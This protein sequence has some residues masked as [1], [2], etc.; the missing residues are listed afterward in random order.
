MI[1]L[2][3]INPRIRIGR[4]LLGMFLVFLLCGFSSCTS[5][6]IAH[7]KVVDTSPKMPVLK[8]K[9][10]VDGIALTVSTKV[11]WHLDRIDQLSP[12]LNG[13]FE[14]AG[15]GLGVVIYVL[16]TGIRMTHEEF[17]DRATPFLGGSDGDYV[18]DD[19]GKMHGAM[20]CLGHGTHVAA[21][22]AGKTFGVA[23]EPR[24]D[25]SE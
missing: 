21:L 5:E 23:P 6:S 1:T 8:R 14:P 9:G 24:S 25:Q 16:D 20:D 17:Q 3:L 12:V 18:G 2:S 7:D 10:D 4:C 13:K 19:W 15:I 11:P 22:A